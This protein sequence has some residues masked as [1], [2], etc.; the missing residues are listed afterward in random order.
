[1]SSQLGEGKSDPGGQQRFEHYQRKKRVGGGTDG[2]RGTLWSLKR[3][4]D[5][6]E[7][8]KASFSR[9]TTQGG[10]KQGGRLRTNKKRLPIEKE[11]QKVLGNSRCA[12][13]TGGD[14]I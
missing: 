4:C 5:H 3:V 7:N 10:G 14:K 9:Q 12:G 8:R 2:E 1:M 11:C 13:G 6:G